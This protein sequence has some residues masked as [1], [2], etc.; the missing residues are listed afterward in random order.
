MMLS[1]PPGKFATVWTCALAVMAIP[2]A[3]R[4][5]RIRPEFRFMRFV[6]YSGVPIICGG[7]PQDSQNLSQQLHKCLV[8]ALT[9]ILGPLSGPTPARLRDPSPGPRRQ[10]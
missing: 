4:R 6:L 1:T 7:A 10:P 3:H 9:E 5:V 8:A 2:R